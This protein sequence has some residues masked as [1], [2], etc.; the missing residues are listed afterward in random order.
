MAV[1]F[2]PT[3]FSGLRPALVVAHPG[4]ELRVHGWL[5]AAR[6]SVFVLTDGSGHPGQSRVA[7]TTRVL[8]Q[9]GASPGSI[10][11]RFSDAEI[12]AAMLNGDLDL[13]IRLADELAAALLLGQVDYVVGDA[14]ENYNPSHDICSLL[15][16]AAV[17][18]AASAR[19]QVLRNFD[20]LLVGRPD[21]CPDA[22]RQG[23]LW[24]H[25][26]DEALSRKLAAASGYPEFRREVESA[27]RIGAGAYR[28]EC[29]RPAPSRPDLEE[30]AN[31]PPFYEQ[32]GEQQVAAS[33]YTRVLRR[34]DHILPLRDA[35][36]QHVD[37]RTS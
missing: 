12:Y 13:F 29:L 10:Y 9:C 1:S 17:E 27:L 20:F 28:V 8:R 3:G 18:I 19:S 36:Y 25:L 23:A 7:A 11:G 16:G 15:I 14:I 21:S 31:Q 33:Y 5:E 26:D 22:L 30:R 2:L 35:L 32:Y 37:K 6:P 34:Q 4:H 24:I